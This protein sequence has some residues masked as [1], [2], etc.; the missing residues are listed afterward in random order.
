MIPIMIL[1]ASA[2]PA[3]SLSKKVF[4]MNRSHEMAFGVEGIVEAW[5]PKEIWQEVVN[6]SKIS[7]V[8]LAC[9][10]KEFE[11]L[12]KNYRPEGCFGKVQWLSFKGDPGDEPYLPLKMIQDFDSS[13]QM[14]TFIPAS[15][16]G[17]YLSLSSIDKFASKLKRHNNQL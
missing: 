1:A 10:N 7:L 6:H 4:F 16:N 9:V 8:A 12:T 11:R 3:R 2:S 14:L 5:L 13:K 15:L 17:I